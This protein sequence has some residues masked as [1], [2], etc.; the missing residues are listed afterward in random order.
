MSFIVHNI[1]YSFHDIHFVLF[2]WSLCEYISI[3][4]WGAVKSNCDCISLIWC[5]KVTVMLTADLSAINLIPWVSERWKEGAASGSPLTVRSHRD[6]IQN[7]V[8]RMETLGMQS[9]CISLLRQVRSEQPQCS[10]LR[11]EWS[12]CREMIKAVMDQASC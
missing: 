8:E 4:E 9:V 7:A 11:Q 1:L 5:W 3:T 10:D 12:V 2:V 6:K